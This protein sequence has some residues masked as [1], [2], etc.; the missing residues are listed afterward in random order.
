MGSYL[1]QGSALS[2]EAYWF[3]RLLQMLYGLAMTQINAINGEAALKVEAHSLKVE[4]SAC[5]LVGSLR[6]GPL[7]RN[8]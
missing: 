1:S 6:H 2:V 7:E 5:L 3:L 4:P 8:Q